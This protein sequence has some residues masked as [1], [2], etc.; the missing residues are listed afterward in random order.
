MRAFALFSLLAFA[1]AAGEAPNPFD[2]NPAPAANANDARKELIQARQKANDA[3]E[4]LRRRIADLEEKIKALSGAEADKAT[5]DLAKL[6]AAYKNAVA[7]VQRLDK[8]LKEPPA[9][10]KA[11]DPPPPPPPQEVPVK[12]LEMQD[13]AAL[14]VHRLLLAED[15]GR[16]TYRV[17]F[18]NGSVR[19]IDGADVVAVKDNRDFFKQYKE[20]SARADEAKAWRGLL[21]EKARLNAERDKSPTP[22][23]LDDYVE[24]R[25]NVQILTTQADTAMKIAAAFQQKVEA[26]I[27]QQM[28]F[29]LVE[30]RNPLKAITDLEAFKP[31]TPKSEARKT[32][33]SK[34]PAAEVKTPAIADAATDANSSANLPPRV[35]APAEKSN[36]A[37]ATVPAQPAANSLEPIPPENVLPVEPKTVVTNTQTGPQPF[38]PRMNNEPA[39]QNEPQNEPRPQG[40]G[41]A[42]AHDPLIILLSAA[43]AL[44]SI[45]A[46]FFALLSAK[47][48]RLLRQLQSNQVNTARFN[49][50]ECGES[51]PIA[52]RSCRFCQAILSAKDK[53][54][55]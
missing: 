46:I 43:L 40:S 20:R 7:E 9:V 14:N 54:K 31:P 52:A 3:R 39:T 6:N 15:N 38:E 42:R 10:A 36:E 55:K 33:P 23:V 8:K 48:A 16:K 24:N 50:P 28:Y 25:K 26:F 37:P 30:K 49:C 21:D 2:P 22:Q 29:A 27:E 12:T 34:P 5:A 4:A 45:A 53:T 18:F 11:P 32:E 19:T 44:A 41:P 47:S 1:T 13:G 17:T 35:D 51:I